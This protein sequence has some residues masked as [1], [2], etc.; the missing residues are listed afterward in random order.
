MHSIYKGRGV[1]HRVTM[2][3][4]TFEY[5]YELEKQLQRQRDYERS[6]E[7]DTIGQLGEALCSY[8]AAKAHCQ[9]TLARRTPDDRT[10]SE[11][12]SAFRK[13]EKLQADLVGLHGALKTRR[14]A[15]AEAEEKL[16]AHEKVYEALVSSG[17][18]C[19]NKFDE[20][21]LRSIEALHVCSV[22]EQEYRDLPLAARTVL[23]T[24]QV[25]SWFSEISKFNCVKEEIRDGIGQ[26]V[27]KDDILPIVCE[28]L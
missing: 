23:T 1:R 18:E 16:H 13:L 14:A 19:A 28:M 6:K 5:D 8:K 26:E 20:S 15:A 3:N 10:P 11:V 21:E 7:A 24:A 25:K 2:T 4:S 9:D 22:T 27:W 12:L 17:I